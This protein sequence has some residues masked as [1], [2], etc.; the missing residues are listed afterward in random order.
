MADIRTHSRKGIRQTL[1]S[2]LLLIVPILQAAP[3]CC[4]AQSSSGN[5]PT[6]SSEK[7]CCAVHLASARSCCATGWSGAA[8]SLRP[9]A[10][11]ECCI[12]KSLLTGVDQ[13]RDR[14]HEELRLDD[15]A[16][17]EAVRPAIV[18]LK[19]RGVAETGA[20]ANLMAHNRRQA[21]L[22]VWRN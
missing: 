18:D 22:C 15:L 7:A 21:Y 17:A 5:L 4:E 8:T 12:Q 1:L 20:D 11:C 13:N 14:S 3:C 9:S 16:T 19:S 10:D 2:C 6:V